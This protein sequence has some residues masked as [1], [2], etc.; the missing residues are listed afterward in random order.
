MLLQPETVPEK[1]RLLQEYTASICP[2]IL[3]LWEVRKHE[4]PMWNNRSTRSDPAQV[5]LKRI[6]EGHLLGRSGEYKGLRGAEEVVYCL[7]VAVGLQSLAQEWGLLESMQLRC[8]KMHQQR[9]KESGGE[10]PQCV[11]LHTTAAFAAREHKSSARRWQEDVYSQRWGFLLKSILS[12]S[13]GLNPTNVK[14][15]YVHWHECHEEPV[16]GRY[17][18]HDLQD[19]KPPLLFS[20]I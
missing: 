15:C 1:E 3:L 9:K 17:S 2:G 12:H 18:D 19:L 14:G 13:S 10:N 5:E 7:W 20:I 11:A 8:I 16:M 4:M 6:L